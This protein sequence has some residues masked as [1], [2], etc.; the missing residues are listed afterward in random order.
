MTS[1]A[2]WRRDNRGQEGGR[3]SSEEMMVYLGKRACGRR[4]GEKCSDSGYTL[5]V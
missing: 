1:T 3:D 2:L 5:E 4:D